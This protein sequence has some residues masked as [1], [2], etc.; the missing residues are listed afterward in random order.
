[1]RGIC[2]FGGGDARLTL[3]GT[4]MTAP[5]FDTLSDAKIP[6]QKINLAADLAFFGGGTGAA[7]YLNV[8]G[9]GGK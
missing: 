9:G 1:M 6:I 8:N 2:W 4:S 5:G 7:V 3:G